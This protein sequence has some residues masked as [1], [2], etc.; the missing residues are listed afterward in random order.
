MYWHPSTYLGLSV[1]CDRSVVFSEYSGYVSFVNK[2][3]TI[4]VKQI[5]LQFLISYVNNNNID[6]NVDI[7]F[8]AHDTFLG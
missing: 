8:S 1:T 6:I 7:R 2:I 5:D 4:L 3:D